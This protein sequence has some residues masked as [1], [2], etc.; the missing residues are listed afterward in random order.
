MPYPSQTNATQIRSA[1]LALLET[2]GEE[3]VT[4]R[5]VAKSLGISPNAIYHYYEDKDA[6]LAELASEGANLLFQALQAAIQGRQGR[7]ALVMLAGRY[8]EFASQRQPLYKLMMR[9]HTYTPEQER[10]LHNL[11]D[12]VRG[13]VGQ[14]IPNADEA[15]VALW[16]FLHGMVELEGAN[17]FHEGK[18]RTGIQ[19][20]LAALFAGFQAHS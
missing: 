6:L 12:F 18:P 9:A 20:G 3:E 14:V 7:E 10:N 13:Q 19:A 5:G 17:V 4:L 1:A 15:A 11:W 8:V 2:H 16:A